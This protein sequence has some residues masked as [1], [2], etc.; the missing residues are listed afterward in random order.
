MGWA[1]L[2][3]LLSLSTLLLAL[4]SH[5]IDNKNHCLSIIINFYALYG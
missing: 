3:N 5:N 1:F 2:R 4:V